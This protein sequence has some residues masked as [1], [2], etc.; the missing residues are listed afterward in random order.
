MAIKYAILIGCN[1]K[2]TGSPLAGCIPDVLNMRDY[3]YEKGYNPEHVILLTDDP[4]V[5]PN[6]VSTKENIFKFINETTQKMKKGDSLFFHMSSHGGQVPCYQMDERDGQDETVYG[7]GLEQ[8]IDDELK[9]R[10][11]NKIPKG[12]KMRAI[13]DACHSGTSLDLPWELKGYESYERESTICRLSN[14]VMCISGCRDN[15]LSSDSIDISGNPAGALS[16]TILQILNQQAG[17]EN[18]TWD[19]FLT[20]IRDTLQNNGY[21]QIPQLSMGRKGLEKNN[22]DI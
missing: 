1:Y 21:D 10:L 5:T 16:M 19:E 22:V 17:N 6:L 8:I 20:L 11:I 3:L 13:I 7:A 18:L 4:D 2:N 15:Q 14:D 9:D 12:C